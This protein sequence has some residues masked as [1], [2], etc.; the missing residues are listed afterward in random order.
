MPGP[1]V[2]TGLGVVCALGRTVPEFADALRA[3][4]CGVT[5]VDGEPVAHAPA[6]DPADAADRAGLPERRRR[7]VRAA[8]ARAPEPVLAA[9]SAATEAWAAARAEGAVPGERVGLVVGGHNLTGWYAH[10]HHD[11]FTREPAYL[12]AR[13]ALQ[14]QDTDHVGT[15]SEAFGVKG[16]GY[17]VGGSSASGTVALVHGARL[18]RHGVVDLCLVLGAMVRLAPPERASLARLGVLTRD[19]PA[20]PFDRGR[21]GFVPGEGT[22]CLVLESPDHAARRGAPP[23][24]ELAGC[25]QALDANRYADPDVA[26]EVRAMRQALADA[27]VDSCDVDYVNAHATATPAGDDAEAAALRTVFGST[28]PGGPADRPAAGGPWV[29]ATKALVGHC[30]S[31]AGA[32]EAVATVVQLRDG[33]LH[34]NPHLADPVDASLRLVGRVAVPA[35]TRYAVSN[36]FGFGGI[37]SSV[38]L[39]SI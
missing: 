32:V 5:E 28:G 22:A 38:V 29:N 8:A 37:N 23:L 35:R 6:V 20:R 18:V 7:A 34:P 19:P 4:R 12:P 25:G 21:S 9:L 15:V 10:R 13:Y 27:G 31:A 16:E 1:V 14:I 3:G 17:T 2:V 33:F 39:R 24:A 26:G 36:S 11:T 30:L